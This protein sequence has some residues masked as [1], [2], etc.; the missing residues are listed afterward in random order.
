MPSNG[1]D[2]RPLEALVASIFIT[3]PPQPRIYYKM[4]TISNKVRTFSRG[5]DIRPC[6][7]GLAPLTTPCD[8]TSVDFLTSKLGNLFVNESDSPDHQ[9]PLDHSGYSRNASAPL[10]SSIR[11][12]SLTGNGTEESPFTEVDIHLLQTGTPRSPLP[13]LLVGDSHLLWRAACWEA[14]FATAESHGFTLGKG[15]NLTP[16]TPERSPSPRIDIIC[17]GDRHTCQHPS[18]S[19]SRRTLGPE[20]CADRLF[21]NEFYRNHD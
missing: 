1:L 15:F 19:P 7:P 11:L 8:A 9:A 13:K 10:H 14:L 5:R 2:S 12:P 3:H 17:T 18:F 16:K 4:R 6:L 20:Y 21:F